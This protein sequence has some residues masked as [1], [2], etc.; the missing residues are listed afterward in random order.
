MTRIAVRTRDAFVAS[1][2]SPPRSLPL[3][4]SLFV[5][6]GELLRELRFM[7]FSLS[8]QVCVPHEGLRIFGHPGPFF[9]LYKVL[10]I[11]PAG[12]VHPAPPGPHQQGRQPVLLGSKGDVSIRGR[13]LVAL[14]VGSEWRTHRLLQGSTSPNSN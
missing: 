5:R 12:T 13:N 8:P 6:D 3:S 9:E 1:V 7:S 4:S 14:P 2:P 10:R 11:L